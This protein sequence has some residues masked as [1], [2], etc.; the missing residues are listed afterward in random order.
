MNFGSRA[1]FTESLQRMGP[2]FP[3]LYPP[4]PAPLLHPNPQATHLSVPHHQFVKV[5]DPNLGQNV[6]LQNSEKALFGKS[7]NFKVP[8]AL[9]ARPSL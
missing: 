2:M 6:F 1:I 7:S 4:S 5:P 8:A 9:E 3:C